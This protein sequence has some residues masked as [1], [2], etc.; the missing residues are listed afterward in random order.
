MHE[1]AVRNQ[2]GRLTVAERN[3]LSN[4]VNVGHLIA[5]LQSKARKSLKRLTASG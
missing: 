4:Y 5:L 3:E 1:L 2:D